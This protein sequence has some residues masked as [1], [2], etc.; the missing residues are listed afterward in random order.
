MSLKYIVNV[1]AIVAAGF[2]A[3]ASRAFPPWV[4]GWVGFAVSVGIL[5]LAL[6]ALIA[7]QLS[8]RSV[9]YGLTGLVS[10]WSLVAALVF[11]GPALGWLVFADALALAAVALVDL[12]VHEVSTERVVHTIEVTDS[13][14]PQAA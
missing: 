2:L 8:P 1:I 12:T 14:L 6:A 5:V 13:R 11:N 7:S 10:A 4:P 9:G 3:V